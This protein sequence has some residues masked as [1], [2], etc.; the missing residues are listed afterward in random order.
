MTVR[1][2]VTKF[3]SDLRTDEVFTGRQLQAYCAVKTGNNPF[4]DS[5]LRKLRLIREDAEFKVICIDIKKSKY[6][7]KELQEGNPDSSRRSVRT[8]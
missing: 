2:A 1:Q 8:A 5:C 6:I 7:K 4:P 3:V